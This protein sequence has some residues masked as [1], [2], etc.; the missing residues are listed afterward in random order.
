MQ[1][2]CADFRYEAC[3]NPQKSLEEKEGNID[4]ECVLRIFSRGD[5]EDTP[6]KHGDSLFDQSKDAEG[7]TGK[8]KV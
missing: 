4:A 8:G 2:V 6:D 3:Q 5:S 1:L 7:D